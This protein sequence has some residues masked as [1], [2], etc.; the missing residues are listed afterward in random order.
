MNVEKVHACV[1][2]GGNMEEIDFFWKNPERM[3]E[4]KACTVD[5]VKVKILSLVVMYNYTQW[6]A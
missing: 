1:F 4:A 6:Y 5:N 3:K 2:N